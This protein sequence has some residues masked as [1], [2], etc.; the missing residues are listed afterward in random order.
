MFQT[1]TVEKMFGSDHFTKIYLSS[2]STDKFFKTPYFRRGY[3]KLFKCRKQNVIRYI[4]NKTP[5]ACFR[6]FQKKIENILNE[7]APMKILDQKE[8]KLY[9]QNGFLRKFCV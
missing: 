2:L 4:C 9:R 1:I 6:Y 5:I 8:K 3:I 7:L